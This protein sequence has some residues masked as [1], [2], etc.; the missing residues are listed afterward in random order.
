MSNTLSVTAGNDLA[1]DPAYDTVKKLRVDY[2]LNGTH[3]T[4][5]ADEK[6]TLTI[7][8]PGETPGRLVIQS[9]VYGD[10]SATTGPAAM[11]ATI[12]PPV[13]VTQYLP[14]RKITKL[15]PGTYIVDIG[16]NMV[17]WGQAEGAGRGGDA[18]ANALRGGAEPGRHALHD[19]PALS[20]CDRYLYLPGRRQHR[21]L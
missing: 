7:P 19:K 13:R 16:Q 2:T 4:Q 9:A 5:T 14:A 11:V 17:G 21:G 1:G 6:G 3:H 8:A 12:G 15:V 20:P 10:L 18:G